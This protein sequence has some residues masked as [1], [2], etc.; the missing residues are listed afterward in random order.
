MNPNLTYRGYDGT[1]IF[2]ENEHVFYGKVLGIRSSLTYEGTDIDELIADF[3]DAID[4]YLESCAEHNWTPEKPFK[5]SF[6][7]RIGS[8][9][10]RDAVRSAAMRGM[11]LNTFVIHAIRSALTLSAE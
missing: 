8:D 6:N 1:V 10:H 9:L 11:N 2:S 7:V 4:D 5:G 3:H